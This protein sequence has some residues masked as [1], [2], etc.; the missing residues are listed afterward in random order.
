MIH[1]KGP[2]MTPGVYTYI[3]LDE[4]HYWLGSWSD[5]LGDCTGCYFVF[6]TVVNPRA[7]SS[8]KLEGSKGSVF[9]QEAVHISALLIR[10]MPIM[11]MEAGQ[12]YIGMGIRTRVMPPLLFAQRY[13]WD[14][15]QAACRYRV[16]SF[17]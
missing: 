7:T 17:S 2:S 3:D 6:E 13:V 14:R 16:P 11:N 8:D 1:D 4:D 5:P 10:R 15:R 12:T 9:C